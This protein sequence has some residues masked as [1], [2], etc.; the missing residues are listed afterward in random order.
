MS[1]RQAKA[2]PLIALL[3][4]ASWAGAALGRE[5]IDF[6]I[7]VIPDRGQNTAAYSIWYK[8]QVESCT[9][10]MRGNRPIIEFDPRIDNRGSD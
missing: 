8:V 7:M 9:T 4:G 2:F 10:N 3:L 1:N 5:Q 6:Q